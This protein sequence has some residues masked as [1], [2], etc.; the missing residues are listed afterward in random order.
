MVFTSIIRC[1]PQPL[2]DRIMQGAD[3]QQVMEVT[4]HRSLDG[5]RTYKHTL[6]KKTF[7]TY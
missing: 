2:L 6:K 1:V 5:V 7:Q 3:E 4:G